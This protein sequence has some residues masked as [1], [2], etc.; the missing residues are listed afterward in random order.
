MS[1]PQ[2]LNQRLARVEWGL[3]VV[4]VL[5]VGALVATW[6]THPSGTPAIAAAPADVSSLESMQR[7]FGWMAETVTP[8]VVFIEAERKVE[9]P[10]ATTESP[11]AQPPDWWREFFGPDVPFFRG[12]GLGPHQPT[13]EPSIPQVGQG[14][15]VVFDPDG[16]ILTNNHVV[17]N[18]D[19]VTVHLVNGEAYPAK[20]IGTDELTDLAVIKIDPKRPLATAQF[21]D[22][23]QMSVGWWVMAIGYPFGGSRYQGRFDQALRYEPTVTVGVVS[24]KDRQ[25]E[26]DR[27]GYPFR[28]LIQ[29]DAPINPGNSGGP[30]VDVHAKV[31]GINQA[32]FTSGPWG[33]NI[34]VGFA[35]PI[36][37]R[38]KAVIEA[39]KGGETV[40]R[41]RLG[42]AVKPLTDAYKS[43]FG[44]DH[45]VFVENVEPDSPAA[46]AGIKAD[47]IITEYQGKPVVSSDEF[48]TWVQG[49]KP[50]T[51]AEI[52]VLRDGK[53]L[54]LH[55][56]IGSL[57][58]GEGSTTAQAPEP[59]KLGLVVAPLTDEQLR[60]TGL[61]GGVRVESVEP[62]SDAARAGL[63]EGD[64][65]VKINRDTIKDVASY[66]RAVEKL[67]PGDAVVIRYW[68]RG[69]TST[70]GIDSLSR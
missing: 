49:T 66:N 68:R 58:L 14:S 30:L 22:A 11:S 47:D 52:K 59:R 8:A 38:T 63:R 7:G 34:G 40:V 26:S 19:K 24:A 45:G 67:K 62:M 56:T 35:I 50:G 10:E 53:S 20:I 37:A 41:G 17:A 64:V 48:V 46:K 55:V 1:R 13:P 29:T 15:G 69:Q 25:I 42:V 51:K 32:I 54:T 4:A 2:N 57:S 33:G 27:P 12:P 31:I 65:I 5:L 6:L 70:A 3:G 16:Y 43:A 9:T 44:A 60:D 28:D 39:L 36:N 21:G 61:S 18:A 23:D